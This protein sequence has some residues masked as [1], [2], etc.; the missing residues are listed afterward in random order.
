MALITG[1]DCKLTVGAKDFS[2][3]INS[4]SLS[5]STESTTYDTLA[6]QRAGAGKESSTLSITFAYDS[7]DAN[8]LFDTL[9]T[10][11]GK[12]V[13]FVAV[14]G[15][16]QFTGKAVA[17]RPSV[18]ANAGQVSEVSV[19]MDVDGSVTKAPVPAAK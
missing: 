3:V 4:F 6:G 15:A 14:A 9:W 8:S 7:G 12:T 16:S 2:T 11:T 5:F 19:E 10:E 17:V 13:D 18:P 1:S